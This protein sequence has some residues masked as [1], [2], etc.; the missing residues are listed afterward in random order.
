MKFKIS[1]IT[2]ERKHLKIATVNSVE[3]AVVIGAALAR[4]RAATGPVDNGGSIHI[5]ADARRSALTS[6]SISACFLCSRNERFDDL[7]AE[8][9]K[10]KVRIKAWKAEQRRIAAAMK[11]ARRYISHRHGDDWMRPNN[12]IWGEGPIRTAVLANDFETAA[13]LLSEAGIQPLEEQEA[14]AVA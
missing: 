12:A 13:R 3:D 8:I 14:A 1:E 10:L 9:A 4:S 11:F 6:M 2:H 7:A 5:N